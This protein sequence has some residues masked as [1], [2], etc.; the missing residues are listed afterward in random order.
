M[1]S[2][3]GSKHLDIIFRYHRPRIMTVGSGTNFYRL[4]A[5]P[6]IRPFT[7]DKNNKTNSHNSKDD[8]RNKEQQPKT[9]QWLHSKQRLSKTHVGDDRARGGRVGRWGTGGSRKPP[10]HGK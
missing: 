1:N 2:A 6:S 8:G 4:R 3:I 10:C 5:V 7:E 9:P